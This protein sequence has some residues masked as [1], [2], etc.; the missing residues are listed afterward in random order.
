MLQGTYNYITLK[1]N[2]LEKLQSHS[3]AGT[4]LLA[5]SPATTKSSVMS[6]SC[7]KTKLSVYLNETLLSSGGR[8]ADH[9][10][11]VSSGG[12]AVTAFKRAATSFALF[13]AV[14]NLSFSRSSW[15]CVSRPVRSWVLHKF[16]IQG[17]KVAVE[18]SASFCGF[19]GSD[20]KGGQQHSTDDNL[21]AF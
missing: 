14:G 18:G 13:L 5:S 15:A 9:A 2:T 17:V 8:A 6:A 3:P 4:Q 20:H 11:V 19:Q 21:H 7:N 10:A 16:L 1:E 12:C